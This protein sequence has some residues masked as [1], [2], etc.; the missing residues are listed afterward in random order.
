[1]EETDQMEQIEARLQSPRGE[2]AAGYVNATDL[3]AAQYCGVPLVCGTRTMIAHS[4][5]TGT[6][7]A[8]IDNESKTSNIAD[9]FAS[10]SCRIAI[11]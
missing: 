1:M 11:H 3:H 9:I 7:H 5:I 10:D 6:R 2:C 4:S 8:D